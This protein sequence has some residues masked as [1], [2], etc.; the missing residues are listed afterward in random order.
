MPDPRRHQSDEAVARP[1]CDV[2]RACTRI[3][4]VATLR[5]DGDWSRRMTRGA[6][7]GVFAAGVLAAWAPSTDRQPPR[8]LRMRDAITE[9]RGAA[10]TA[11]GVAT[12]VRA[13]AVRRSAGTPSLAVERPSA[14][15]A[16]PDALSLLDSLEGID[17]AGLRDGGWRSALEQ[18]DQ[19]LA[20]FAALSLDALL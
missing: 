15:P 3:A 11:A 4:T 6:A 8:R 10:S 16:D 18:L 5:Y 19:V 14:F 20:G 2:T 7:I 13:D 9:R 1:A 17:K 12:G